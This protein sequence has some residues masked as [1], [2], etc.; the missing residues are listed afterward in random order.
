VIASDLHPGYLSSRYA[1]ERAES[2]ALPLLKIQHHHAH[3]AAC[4]ADNSWET[5]DPVAGL[6]FDGTGLG[7][8]G[9]IWGGEALIGSYLSFSRFSHL[10][11]TAMPGGELAVKKPS[12]MALSLLLRYGIEWEE[13]F[14]PVAALCAEER[15]TIASQIRL[16]INSPRTSSMGRLFDAVASLIGLR[17]IAT[18]EGQA[19]IELEAIADQDE[20]GFYPFDLQA[21]EFDAAPVIVELIKDM[22][23][24]VPANRLSARFHN[25]VARLSLELCQSIR[26]GTGIKTIA[27]SGGVWQNRVLFERT[28]NLLAADNFRVLVHRQVSPND[29]GIALGQAVIGAANTSQQ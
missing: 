3:L 4:L 1:E 5:M 10:A 9:T 7:T 25:S 28:F 11:Y 6:C 2:H 12:R 24:G 21:G 26:R 13:D 27:L 29:G 22:R 23:Q 19:A 17:H 8:D 16:G 15:M 18:Y 14:P 20:M